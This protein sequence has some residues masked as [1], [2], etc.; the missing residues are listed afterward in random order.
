MF[1]SFGTQ[2]FKVKFPTRTRL[3]HAEERKFFHM[4]CNDYCNKTPLFC[5]TATGNLNGD[6]NPRLCVACL[7]SDLEFILMLHCALLSECSYRTSGSCW[8]S[9]S[10]D[11]R[12]RSFL[13]IIGAA[14]IFSAHCALQRTFEPIWRFRGSMRICCNL[15]RPR[16]SALNL[17][18]TEGRKKSICS[19]LWKPCSTHWNVEKRIKPAD[20]IP[21][22]ILKGCNKSIGG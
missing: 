19:I 10:P 7:S 22:T 5:Q 17:M 9:C 14:R 12:W 3:S 16:E 18:S 6:V 11:L 1:I 8:L 20:R 15:Y 13:F 2:L 21:N 4:E